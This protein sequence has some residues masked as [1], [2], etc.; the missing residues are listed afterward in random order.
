MVN[1]PSPVVIQLNLYSPCQPEDVGQEGKPFRSNRLIKN[2][3][4]DDGFVKFRVS[5]FVISTYISQLR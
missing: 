2:Y 1:C 3:F 4:K 5:R